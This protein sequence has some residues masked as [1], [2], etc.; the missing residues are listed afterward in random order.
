MLSYSCIMWGL[1]WFSLHYH[2]HISIDLLLFEKMWDT[3][4]LNVFIS[5]FIKNSICNNF[6]LFTEVA[7][8]LL[9]FL[10]YFLCYLVQHY[11]Y[12][13]TTHHLAMLVSWSLYVSSLF[14]VTFR[15]CIDWSWLS[16]LI[17]EHIQDSHNELTCDISNW[18]KSLT[19]EMGIVVHVTFYF[20]LHNILSGGL[21]LM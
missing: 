6:H 14:I 4:C 2:L 12:M 3:I 15:F 9:L 21:F 18:L 19:L 20:I 11:V 7:V 16:E 17:G 5:L 10:C 1:I 8:I 13:S